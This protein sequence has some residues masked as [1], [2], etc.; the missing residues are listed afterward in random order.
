MA[1]PWQT[2]E[3]ISTE[4]G[5]LELRQR[6]DHDF[7]IT[8]GGR[9][10]MNSMAHLSEVSLG[11]L[12]C[13]NLKKQ[14]KPRVLVGGLGMGFT[15]RAILDTLPPTGRVVVAELNPVVLEWCKGPLADLTDRAATDSRVTLKIADVSHLIQRYAEDR[16]RENFDAVVLDLYTGPYTGTNERDDPLYGSIA[17]DT[18]R[19]ALKPNGVFAVWGEDY[20]AAF[21]K[22]LRKAGF[23]V[24]SKRV[25]GGGPRH[26]IYMGKLQ[27]TRRKG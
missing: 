12:A 23:A 3:S 2:I 6:G 21:D 25:R 4:E 26:V 22:R 8:V 19:S 15:L 16:K 17:I 14:A 20:D 1:Q 18:T 9:I 7:L 24:T 10:L 5:T 27:A 11:K 13:D